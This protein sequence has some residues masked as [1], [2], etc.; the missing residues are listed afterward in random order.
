MTTYKRWILLRQILNAK[1]SAWYLIDG[2][3]ILH[4]PYGNQ[5]C[6]FTAD[7]QVA[8]ACNKDAIDLPNGMF[9]YCD[10]IA[11]LAFDEFPEDQIKIIRGS[12]F[13][14]ARVKL[15]K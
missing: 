6:G 5:S 10:M 14:T 13:D 8:S 12:H 4:N 2:R 11:F 9:M 7:Y 15:M 3:T 1:N